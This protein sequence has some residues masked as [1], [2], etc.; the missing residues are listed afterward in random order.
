MVCPY[1]YVW[2]IWSSPF[3]SSILHRMVF[4]M[5]KKSLGKSSKKVG[6]SAR[7]T[8]QD[9]IF[10]ASIALAEGG[11]EAVRVEPLARRLSVT[12]GSFYW[13]FESRRAL[14]LAVLECW[15]AFGTDDII[16]QVEDHSGSDAREKMRALWRLTRVDDLGVDLAIRDWARRDETV[17]AFVERVDDRRMGYLRG[18][19]LAMDFSTRDAE[20]RSM[21][22]YSLL[23]G[24]YFIAARHAECSREDV[25]N[26]ALELLEHPPGSVLGKML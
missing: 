17:R 22:A 6:S 1:G 25:L 26:A 14:H 19:F 4:F 23:I 2:L 3:A 11:I 16:T 8:R 7:K 15:E 5:A 13:H 24:D 9:W 12:K 10:A 20:V 21:L 18:L